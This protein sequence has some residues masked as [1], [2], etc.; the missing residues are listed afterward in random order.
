MVHGRPVM[1]A[2][3][4]LLATLVG[5]LGTLAVALE[6]GRA[7]ASVRLT[8]TVAALSLCSAVA[9]MLDSPLAGPSA[10][11]KT[12]PT[13]APTAV[14]LIEA[15]AQ[16]QGDRRWAKAE[17]RGL[18]DCAWCPQLGIVPATARTAGPGNVRPVAVSVREISRA[19]F[20]RFLDATGHRVSGGC[21]TEQGFDASTDWRSPGFA[22][23]AADPV[24]CV[25]R[26]DAQAFVAWLSRETGQ[27][28]RLPTSRELGTSD[29]AASRLGA[30]P[31]NDLGFRVARSLSDSE[32][33]AEDNLLNRLWR[34]FSSLP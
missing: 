1:L 26:A 6:S 20:Q 8:L 22:Q 14:G 30:R 4:F 25:T 16:I 3:A 15:V 29:S 31:S 28:Y 34:A 5:L 17:G 21:W 18:A 32:V 11:A 19:E 33:A 27:T 2:A 12:R 10:A 7:Q 13:A 24:V 9:L 23:D